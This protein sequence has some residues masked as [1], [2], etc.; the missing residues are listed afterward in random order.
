LEVE[1]MAHLWIQNKTRKWAVSPLSGLELTLRSIVADSI[2]QG[3]AADGIP[4]DVHLIRA[5]NDNQ[6]EWSILAAMESGVT[7]NGIPL[8]L[9]L[10]VLKD[11][12]EI[13]W[14]QD[15]SAFYSSEELAAIVDFPTEDR[16]IFCPRCKQQI[17]PE[18]PAV[19]CPRCG[20]WHHQS[21]QL[22]CYTYADKCAVCSRETNLDGGYDWIPEEI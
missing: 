20:I 5:G 16:K 12:D 13:R 8:L 22:P 7:V 1:V 10:Q 21:E 6:E 17:A 9:G 15:G 4:E 19:R 2:I 18:T 11:R 14:D 3:V